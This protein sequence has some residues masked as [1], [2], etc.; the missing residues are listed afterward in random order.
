MSHLYALQRL[1]AFRVMAV[2]LRARVRVA[3]R[4]IVPVVI[5]IIVIIICSKKQFF[6][7]IG[8]GGIQLD[9]RVQS[10]RVNFL[11][12]GKSPAHFKYGPDNNQGYYNKTDITD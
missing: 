9:P 7:A 10:L 12:P 8:V 5:I 1:F 2:L 11:T 4:D 6:G 3:F